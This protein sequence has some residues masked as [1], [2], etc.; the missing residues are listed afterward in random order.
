MMDSSNNKKIFGIL[1]LV[2]VV[3]IIFLFNYFK[4]P[5]YVLTIKYNN[6]F[7]DEIIK[8]KEN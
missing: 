4:N 5:T 3:V 1:L 2:F 6:S 7:E 8:L